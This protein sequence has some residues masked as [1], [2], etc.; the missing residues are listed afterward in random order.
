MD[1]IPE[2]ALD[3]LQEV[4]GRLTAALEPYKRH[5]DLRGNCCDFALHGHMLYVTGLE[6]AG[7]LR[8]GLIADKLQQQDGKC[9]FL[10]GKM[11]GIRDHRAL[12]C[13]L[14]YCDTTHEVS[15]NELYER[16]LKDV[17]AIEVR[18][19]LETSYRPVTEINFQDLQVCQP[20]E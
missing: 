6:A 1:E 18:Y 10:N 9:P 5:C 14:Y 16:F 7:M 19:N 17:R 20:R 13:R 15:R 12:G 3:E 2:Q 11:C 8:A 4:Y